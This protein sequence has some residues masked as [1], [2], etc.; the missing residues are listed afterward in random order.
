MTKSNRNDGTSR[1]T[2]GCGGKGAVSAHDA[3]QAL[4]RLARS[5]SR[6]RAISN[7]RGE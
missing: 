7:A 4:L 6:L 2:I 5:S 1:G 3:H